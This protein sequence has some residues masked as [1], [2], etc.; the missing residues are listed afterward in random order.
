MYQTGEFVVY[1]VQGV[2][3][4]L[5]IEKQLVNRKRVEYLVLEPLNKGESKFYLPTQNPGAMGKLRPILSRDELDALMT[6]EQIRMDCWIAEENPRKQRYRDLLSAA[7]RLPLLQM[8]RALY[9]YQDELVSNGKRIHQC[10]DYFLHDAEKL[11]CSE[12]S[13]VMELSAEEAKQYLRSQLQ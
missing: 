13:L 1:G 12:I 4:V 5:G 8:L 9:R 10:D 11:L 6:S 3:R 7:D 2:C